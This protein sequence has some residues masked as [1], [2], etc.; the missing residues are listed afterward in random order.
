MREVFK[1]IILNAIYE[2]FADIINHEKSHMSRNN[3]GR[4]EEPF[5]SIKFH[6]F[7]Q[8]LAKT[9]TAMDLLHAGITFCDSLSINISKKQGMAAYRYELH[10]FRIS[11][12]P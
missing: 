10:A 11:E 3:E 8:K 7:A 6:K 4:E 12:F 9:C 2:L 5:V 1:S